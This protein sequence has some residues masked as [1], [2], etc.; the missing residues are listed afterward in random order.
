MVKDQG[1]VETPVAETSSASKE[2]ESSTTP[3]PESTATKAKD[4]TVS[5]IVFAKSLLCTD[6]DIGNVFIFRRGKHFQ[7][8]DIERGRSRGN[9]RRGEG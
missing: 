5:F 9:V 8:K 6:P 3:A 1:P 2:A 4:E 7:R